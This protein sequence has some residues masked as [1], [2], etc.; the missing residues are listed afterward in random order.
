M[1]PAAIVAALGTSLESV[2]IIELT[3]EAQKFG[4]K[5]PR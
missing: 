2:D 4:D 3:G 1:P 5:K